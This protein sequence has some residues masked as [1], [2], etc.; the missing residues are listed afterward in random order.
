VR[1]VRAGVLAAAGAASVLAGHA[2]D[3]AGALP[4]VVESAGLRDSA[5][6]PPWTLLAVAGCAALGGAAEGLLRRHRAL[7][8]LVLLSGQTALLGMPELLARHAAGHRQDGGLLLAMALQVLVAGLAVL[9]AGLLVGLL[10]PP[11]PTPL[12][13]LRPVG[14]PVTSY[15][16]VVGRVLA[17]GVRGRG[18]PTS[19]VPH[20]THS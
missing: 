19:A 14:A 5:L 15:P 7:A 20:P 11:S 16:Q 1:P 12:G 13:D 18:P 6:A 10:D 3:A 4:G 9:A 17:G 8:W 2:L